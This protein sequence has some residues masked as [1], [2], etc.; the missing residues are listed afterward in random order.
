MRGNL[1][2]ASALFAFG[3]A[4]P[5]DEGRLARIVLFEADMP[6]GTRNASV[7]TMAEE[8]TETDILLIGDR[9]IARRTI[10][11][12]PDEFAKRGLLTKSTSGLATIEVPAGASRVRMTREVVPLTDPPG[13][14]PMGNGRHYAMETLDS[15][16]RLRTHRYLEF[17]DA[18]G[19]L[20]PGQ[21]RPHATPK[22]SGQPT[23]HPL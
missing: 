14:P 12:G 20:L 19:R 23:E 6:V 9:E 7:R 16:R 11:I 13:L 4:V 15:V 10:S 22:T 18:R 5:E 8:R 1:L 3:C 2:C 17:F 21:R